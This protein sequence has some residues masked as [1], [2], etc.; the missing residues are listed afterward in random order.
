MQLQFTKTVFFQEH[1]FSTFTLSLLT[2]HLEVRNHLPAHD[3][4]ELPRSYLV[5]HCT[6]H[7]CGSCPCI[8][9]QTYVSCG[10]VST[11]SRHWQHLNSWCLF[12]LLICVCARAH[13]CPI[14]LSLELNNSGFNKHQPL[15]GGAKLEAAERSVVAD[16]HF[17]LNGVSVHSMPGWALLYGEPI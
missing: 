5:P 1:P 13:L 16:V 10:P 17:L 3:R 15:D 12:F 14:F 8:L 6:M 4:L 11:V 7:H 9:T 2:T